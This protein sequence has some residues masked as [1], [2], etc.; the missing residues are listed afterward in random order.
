MKRI[1][2][3]PKLCSFCGACSAACSLVKAGRFDPAVSRIRVETAGSC[4]PLRAAVCR[5][6][7][8]PACVTACMRGI[9]EKNEATGLVTRRHEDCF[10]C[11]ACAVNCPVGACVQDK[12]LNA[13]TACDLCGGDPL[14]V[15]VCLSGAL[16]Y[17]E[18][19]ENSA[20]VRSRYAEKMFEEQPKQ[21]EELTDGQWEEIRH[22]LETA[23]IHVETDG[24]KAYRDLLRK[25]AEEEG[26]R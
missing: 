16:R 21:A 13:F 2:F 10:R 4:T 25:A 6:C 3:S 7:E 19:A 5:H 20:S 18:D 23:G 1:M 12:E 17:E 26:L 24:L 22:I 11:A 8:D 14:C 15:K 9:I